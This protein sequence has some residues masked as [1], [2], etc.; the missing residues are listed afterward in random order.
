MENLLREINSEAPISGLE[1]ANKLDEFLA[2]NNDVYKLDLDNFRNYPWRF[3]YLFTDDLIIHMLYCGNVIYELLF[4]LKDKLV[5]IGLFSNIQAFYRL[6][7]EES[8]TDI[9]CILETTPHTHGR[10]LNYN[11]LYEFVDNVD[12]HWITK[13]ASIKSSAN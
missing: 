5:Y 3:S 2:D 1:L 4:A 8:F 12:I 11:D 10:F 9:I 7:S 6:V 13:R